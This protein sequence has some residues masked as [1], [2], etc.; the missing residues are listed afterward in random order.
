MTHAEKLRD[1]LNSEGFKIIGEK[2]VKEDKL[3]TVIC[4]EYSGVTEEYSKTEL[5]FGKHTPK[6]KTPEFIEYAEYVKRVYQ[7]KKQGK[8]SA[9]ADV[10]EEEYYIS[11]I[12][13]LLANSGGKYEGY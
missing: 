4:A 13:K 11:E 5:V 3:Y 2:I 12:E 10:S 8:A 7:T 1:F 9:G 6:K